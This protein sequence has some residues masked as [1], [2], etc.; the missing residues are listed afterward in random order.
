MSPGDARTTR[1]WLEKMLARAEKGDAEGDYRRPW[2]L[3]EVL[4]IYFLLRGRWYLGPKMSLASLQN[5]EPA[6][7]EVF[8][9]ALASGASMADI[10]SA[11]TT[12]NGPG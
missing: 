10:R 5:E 8:R 9:K 3:R 4:E 6:H 1:L 2:L 11:V 7:F 12:A